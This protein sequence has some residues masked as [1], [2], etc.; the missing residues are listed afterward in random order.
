MLFE[1]R[2]PW[3]SSDTFCFTVLQKITLQI[4]VVLSDFKICHTSYVI[5]IANLLKP[6]LN[7][8]MKN[9]NSLVGWVLHCSL[10][11]NSTK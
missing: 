8:T 6:V 1:S 10:Y 9:I 3:G 7:I 5:E 4:D 2:K 11:A